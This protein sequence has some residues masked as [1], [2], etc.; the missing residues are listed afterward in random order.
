[1]SWGATAFTPIVTYNTPPFGFEERSNPSDFGTCP[2]DPYSGSENLKEDIRHLFKLED[3]TLP[4][5][6]FSEQFKNGGNGASGGNG[7][8]LSEIFTFY[9]VVLFVMVMSILFY[10]T[11]KRFSAAE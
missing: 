5:S 7:S 1:M 11:R 4:L 6:R 10:V 9:N 8:A 3:E 2:E